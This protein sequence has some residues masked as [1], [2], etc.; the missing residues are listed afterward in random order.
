VV[1][2]NDVLRT[3]EP[4]MEAH[5]MT[6]RRASELTELVSTSDVEN[7]CAAVV[8]LR[9]TSLTQLTTSS[10]QFPVNSLECVEEIPKDLEHG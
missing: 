2:V 4:D 9:T 1:V 8:V 10:V 7:L 6:E 3:H 5:E